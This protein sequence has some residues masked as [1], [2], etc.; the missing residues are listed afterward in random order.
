[1]KVLLFLILGLLSHR[2]LADDICGGD[3]E[4]RQIALLEGNV[5]RVEKSGSLED[6]FN[7]HAKLVAFDCSSKSVMQNSRNRVSALGKE[8]GKRE[9]GKGNL[10]A[11]VKWY[12]RV[13]LWADSERV[14][15]LA[16]R[17][18]Q[19]NKGLF[20]EALNLSNAHASKP[21]GF[22]S[23]LYKIAKENADQFMAKENKLLSSVPRD[24][25]PA[26][27]AGAEGYMNLVH[28]KDWMEFLPE[29]SGVVKKRAELRGDAFAAREDKINSSQ[30]AMQFYQL[31][32]SPKAREQQKK[33][34]EMTKNLE[35]SFEGLKV[36][37]AGSDGVLTKKDE[38]SKKKFKKETEDLEKE[39]DF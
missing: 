2:I 31:A 8:L 5:A 36:K 25:I 15:L 34:N 7:A 37:E 24:S 9:E 33:M 35:K 21:S 14:M 16:V 29:G 26:A 1:M 4:K 17:K 19:L 3:T 30:L 28:A 13:G 18:D 22:K 20:R 32:G 6:K 10:L 23:N 12:D 38:T 11:A 27:K 39:L